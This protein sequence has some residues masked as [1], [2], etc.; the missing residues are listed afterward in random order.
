[1]PTQKTKL[2]VK[3]ATRKGEIPPESRE[4]PLW[5]RCPVS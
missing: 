2:G 5:D 4:V 3:R 1:M